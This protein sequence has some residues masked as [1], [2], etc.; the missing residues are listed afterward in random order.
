MG[1]GQDC[2]HDKWNIA[3]VICGI[4]IPVNKVMVAVIKLCDD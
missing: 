3:L 2:Y 4:D 1:K